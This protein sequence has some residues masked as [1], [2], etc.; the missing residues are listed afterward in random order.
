MSVLTAG[1]SFASH[2]IGRCATRMDTQY[3]AREVAAV[4][5]FSFLISP[6][7]P[8]PPHHPPPAQRAFMLSSLHKSK[9][10]PSITGILWR[11]R[12]RGSISPFPPFFIITMLVESDLTASRKGLSDGTLKILPFYFHFPIESRCGLDL[13]FINRI[14]TITSHIYVWK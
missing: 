3:L 4:I 10:H 14:Y 9:K 8:Y 2:Q 6:P 7:P 5:S 1:F 13:H 12:V 11:S